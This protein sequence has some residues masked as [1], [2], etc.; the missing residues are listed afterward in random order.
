MMNSKP[1][2]TVMPRSRRR[3]RRSPFWLIVCLLAV[4]IFVV[5]LA[6]VDEDPHRPGQ[7]GLYGGGKV[8]EQITG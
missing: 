3:G 4:A 5:T 2:L 7:I 8:L 6:L 1:S